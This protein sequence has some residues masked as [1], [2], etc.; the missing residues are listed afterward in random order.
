M[1]IKKLITKIEDIET[2]A[3]LI[4]EHVTVLK[5]ELKDSGA[6]NN[7]ARKGSKAKSILSEE[8]VK[9]ILAKRNKQRMKRPRNE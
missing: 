5:K 2:Y 7:S 8:H 3:D 6:S 9:N 4:K 1:D